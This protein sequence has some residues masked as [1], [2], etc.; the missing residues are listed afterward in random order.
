MRPTISVSE[1]VAVLGTASTD[2]QVQ[3]EGGAAGDDAAS[4]GQWKGEA[5]V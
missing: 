4:R 1:I 5:G 3:L 2:G